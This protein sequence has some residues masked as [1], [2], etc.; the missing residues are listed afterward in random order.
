MA[1]FSSI[2]DRIDGTITLSNSEAV[3]KLVGKYQL[4]GDDAYSFGGERQYAYFQSPFQA[5]HWAI[6][7]VLYVDI[8]YTG[9]QSFS[10]LLNI[11]CQN[12]ISTKCI[13]CG[14]TLL[15]REDAVSIGK[16][17][18]VLAENVKKQHK[19]YNITTSHNEILVDFA[20]AEANAF[21]AGFGID[22]LKHFM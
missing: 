8:D 15:N 7:D 13:A 4:E 22:V 21:Q 20:D 10:Y 2:K 18:S 5:H 14:R 16:A 11:V 17:L 6:T 12:S 1:S 3:S 19:N 9:C